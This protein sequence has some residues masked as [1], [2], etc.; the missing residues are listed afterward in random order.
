MA[1]DAVLMA[2]TDRTKAIM[3]VH[4]YGHAADMDALMRLAKSHGL[5]VIEDAAEAHGATCRGRLVGGIGDV[6][7]FS[8]YG[9]KII[10]TGEGGMLVTNDSVLASRA[11]FLKDHAMS[12]ERRYWHTAVGYNY[13]MTNIQAALGC[14]QMQKID[15]ML[16]RRA[17][18]LAGYRTAM[19]GLPVEISPAAEW[20]GA[21]SWLVNMILPRDLAPRR[22]ELML[23]M[24][25]ANV[26]T[27]PYFNPVCDMP[28]YVGCRR[29]GRTGGP[30]CEVAVDL[31]ARG[32]SLPSGTLIQEGD[33]EHVA[34]T[35]GKLL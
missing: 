12:P 8:F 11:R 34:D 16:A 24:R 6:G 28:P 13:R 2:L 1:P 3:P 7:C 19:A 15:S 23:R 17:E 25:D 9:N 22:D 21:V 5:L 4:L 32:I 27:R 29:I 18:V 31:S 33:I 35:L 14:A 20:C 26:D 10:T 30:E